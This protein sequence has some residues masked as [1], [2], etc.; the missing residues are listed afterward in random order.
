MICK[1]TV[2]NVEIAGQS[3]TI[4]AFTQ[5]EMERL[6]KKEED[7]VE[8]KDVVALTTVRREAVA[9]ALS[10]ASVE[11]VT[12]AQLSEQMPAILLQALFAA[13]LKANGLKLEP[14]VGEA[15]ASQPA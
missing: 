12:E 3:F 11:P 15:L 6:T 2:F 14:T 13:T 10:L 4:A 9:L 7:A 5:R 1:R 8:A